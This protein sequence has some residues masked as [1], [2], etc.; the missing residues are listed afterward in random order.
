MVAISYISEPDSHRIVAMDGDTQVGKVTYVR[1]G[2]HTLVINHTFVEIPY[3]GQGIAQQLIH[4]II[5]YA[6][7][8]NLKLVPLCSF[9]KS[10]FDK[11]PEYQAL[12]V[13]Q[14]F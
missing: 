13:K 8:N 2:D 12:E 11:H 4:Q 6:I 9:A 10:E 7:E 5:E 14:E 1:A 3:R